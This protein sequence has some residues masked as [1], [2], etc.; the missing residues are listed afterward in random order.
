MAKV[1][2]PTCPLCPPQ[3]SPEGRRKQKGEWRRPPHG[4]WRGRYLPRLQ[5][6]QETGLLPPACH[7]ELCPGACL[8]LSYVARS[9]EREG[10]GWDSPVPCLAGRPC[11]E[12]RSSFPF[13][14]LGAP[15]WDSL[16]VD[17]EIGPVSPQGLG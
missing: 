9:R 5:R 11:S 13:S 7:A 8:G 15:I 14:Q 2:L 17:L 16:G 3:G 1:H 4:G 6:D 12:Y 10:K